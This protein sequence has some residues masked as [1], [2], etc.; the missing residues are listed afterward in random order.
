MGCYPLLT[1]GLDLSTKMKIAYLILAH[2]TPMHMGRLM[3]ALSCDNT[4]FFIHVDKKT[5]DPRFFEKNHRNAL[6]L[7][8]RIPV[9]WGD[10]S[11]VEAIMLL[12]RTAIADTQEYD[13]FVLLSGSDYPVKSCAAIADF[14]ETHRSTEFIHIAEMPSETERKP[15][16]RLTDYKTRPGQSR[17]NHFIEKILMK[18]GLI[19]PQRDHKKY[20]GVLKPYAGSTWWALSREAVKYILDFDRKN[21]RI[22]RFFKNTSFPDEGYFQTILANS[23]FKTHIKG[24]LTYADWS[25]GRRSP[26][27]LSAKHIDMLNQGFHISKNAACSRREILFARKFPDDSAELIAL[28]KPAPMA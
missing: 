3:D 4:G 2:N 25:R 18:I 17:I 10:F 12:M 26:A 28:L 21:I 9:Y 19:T 5:D 20:L 11:Q 14:F 23:E 22:R 24:N 13:R 1:A 27:Y 15:L 6:F 8:K 7:K 16:S